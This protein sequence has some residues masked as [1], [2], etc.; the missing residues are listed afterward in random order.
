MKEFQL[1]DSLMITAYCKS[2]YFK[3]DYCMFVPNLIWHL[4]GAGNPN[5]MLVYGLLLDASHFSTT[6]TWK[7]CLWFSEIK[8][9]FASTSA[10]NA[11]RLIHESL[12][13]LETSKHLT[14]TTIGQSNL[15]DVFND[16]RIKFDLKTHFDP[17]K[18]KAT[19]DPLYA[20]NPHEDSVFSDEIP[21]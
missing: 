6:R 20:D 5:D 12:N 9:C 2:K 14:R 10:T 16:V 19:Y 13:R 7:P 21:F 8:K 1:S 11:S 15:S 3:K 17:D 18:K 4:F